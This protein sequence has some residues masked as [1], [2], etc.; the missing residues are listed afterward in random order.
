MR[1]V[2]DWDTASSDPKREP[3]AAEFNS[4]LQQELSPFL[5]QR[6]DATFPAEQTVSKSEVVVAVEDALRELYERLCSESRPADGGSG[7]REPRDVPEP[8]GGMSQVQSMNDL[9]G[10]F[11][12]ISQSQSMSQ[13]LLFGEAEGNVLEGF[14]NSFWT[15]FLGANQPLGIDVN[16]GEIGGVWPSSPSLAVPN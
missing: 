12:G 4:F 2:S 13:H 1:G 5:Q 10:T 7:V 11:D 16:A 9:E 3:S 15:E 8:G 6:L 14:D